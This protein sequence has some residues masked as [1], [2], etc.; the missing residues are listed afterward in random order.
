VIV[1]VKDEEA[2]VAEL[3]AEVEAALASTPHLWECLWV[4]DGSTDST[5][6]VLQ[7]LA[8]RDPRQ[9][10]LDLDRNYGQSAAMAAGFAAAR[11]DWFATLDGDGQNDPGDLPQLLARLEQGDV[12]MV[13][14]V[15]Q[16][17]QDSLVRKFCSR[18]AN[19]FRNWLT[20][21]QVTDVGCSLRVFRRE[22]VLDMP[23]FKGMHRFFP[24]LVRL[25][26][27]RIT[28]RP[29][30]HR[31]R[32]KGKTKYGINNRLWVGIADTVAV[33]WMQRRFVQARVRKQ[34]D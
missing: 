32:S 14:G 23:V 10:W 31:P 21:E 3:A 24:T 12:D 1:P 29:V 11:G 9:R 5:L 30:N 20:H 8:A 22:C 2:S 34:S 25:R 26:G 6:R 7:D 18:L 28:E 19:R 33:C 17:R 4:N 16:K 13:N 27:F 15:R